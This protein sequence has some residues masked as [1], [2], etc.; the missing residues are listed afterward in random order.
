[1]AGMTNQDCAIRLKQQHK[2]NLCAGQQLMVDVEGENKEVL[3]TSMEDHEA[4]GSDMDVTETAEPMGDDIVGIPE[5]R[6]P[7]TV[8]SPTLPSAAEVEA[9]NLTHTPYQCW[10][11]VCVLKLKAKK[12]PTSATALKKTMIRPCQRWA[13]TMASSEREMVAKRRVRRK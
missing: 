1:M 13:W 11:P 9:H 6:V 3:N 2:P 10:C 12:M 4:K 5:S 8:A 7:R